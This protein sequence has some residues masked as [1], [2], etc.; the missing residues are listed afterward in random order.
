MFVSCPFQLVQPVA[1][2]LSQLVNLPHPKTNIQSYQL[3]YY[4]VIV[5]FLSFRPLTVVH[6]CFATSTSRNGF[7]GFWR[8]KIEQFSPQNL[9]NTVWSFA[10]AWSRFPCTSPQGRVPSMPGDGP[11]YLLVGGRLDCW[12]SQISQSTLSCRKEEACC[13]PE[14]YFHKFQ[15]LAGRVSHIVPLVGIVIARLR[16][17]ETTNSPQLDRCT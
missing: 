12:A 15:Y 4:L 10:K 2:N 13:K 8:G 6:W 5:K 3:S 7:H 9:T 1:S 14:N 11:R 17:C 16:G